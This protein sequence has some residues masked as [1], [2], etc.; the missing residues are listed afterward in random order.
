ME[1]GQWIAGYYGAPLGLTLRCML[2]AG[3]W[4]SSDVVATV[5]DAARAG[6][7]G[8]EPPHPGLADLPACSGPLVEIAAMEHAAWDIRMFAT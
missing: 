7:T 5:V 3:M 8:G 6:T 2:P 1:T 4:G